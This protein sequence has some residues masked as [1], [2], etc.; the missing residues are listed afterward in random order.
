MIR[1]AKIPLRFSEQREE[2]LSRPTFKGA[3]FHV[4]LSQIHHNTSMHTTVQVGINSAVLED[5][6]GEYVG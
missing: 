1:K 3:L 4:A 6:N 5:M 2:R